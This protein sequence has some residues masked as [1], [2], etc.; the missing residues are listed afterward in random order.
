MNL[1]NEFEPMSNVALLDEVERF[2]LA[3]RE[4]LAA[5]GIETHFQ[6]SPRDWA[7]TSANLVLK[8]SPAA[9]GDLIVWESGEAELAVGWEHRP[10]ASTETLA[11]HLDLT[12]VDDVRRT[13]DRLVA[14][15]R[16]DERPAAT[17]DIRRR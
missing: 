5:S 7:K 6:R 1:S 4:R 15:V 11:E 9:E 17:R 2:A 13:L 3:E 12:S 10:D 14:L 8:R 16:A